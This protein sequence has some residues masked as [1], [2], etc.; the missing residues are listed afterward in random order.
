VLSRVVD[1]ALA[2][3]PGGRGCAHW[4]AGPQCMRQGPGCQPQRGGTGSRK[5]HLRALSKQ[6]LSNQ[7]PRVRCT[8]QPYHKTVGAEGLEDAGAMTQPHHFPPLQVPSPGS[9]T[10]GRQVPAGSTPADPCQHELTHTSRASRSGADWGPRT[11]PPSRAD[12][13]PPG[14]GKGPGAP[15]L[16]SAF[17]LLSPK[18]PGDRR[19]RGPTPRR[20]TE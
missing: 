5:Q 9:S 1:F 17:L 19:A 8:G 6:H 4:G 10:P 7:T 18:P 16:E 13:A 12:R 3:A 15:P 11:P 2:R 14:T 20:A